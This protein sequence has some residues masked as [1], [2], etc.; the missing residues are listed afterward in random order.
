MSSQNHCKE[1]TKEIVPMMT[2]NNKKVHKLKDCLFV[3][4][5]TCG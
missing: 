2:E 5:R 1:Q 4:L 3:F